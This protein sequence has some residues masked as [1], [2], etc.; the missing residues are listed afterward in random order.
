MGGRGR[1]EPRRVDFVI[2]SDWNRL[3]RNAGRPLL[4][5]V[6][7]RTEFLRLPTRA[8]RLQ[9]GCRGKEGFRAVVEVAC[10]LLR[11]VCRLPHHSC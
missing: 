11:G 9:G 5:G 7:G 3:E 1:K 2:V 4:A 10:I 6:R 8:F